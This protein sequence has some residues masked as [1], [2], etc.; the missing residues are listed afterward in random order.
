MY[1]DDNIWDPKGRKLIQSKQMFLLSISY[2]LVILF[3]DV[4]PAETCFIPWWQ[5][6]CK[7][8]KVTRKSR[9]DCV[10]SDDFNSWKII[11]SR[12]WKFLTSSN[13]GEVWAPHVWI[14]FKI[15]FINI[16]YK[17]IHTWHTYKL[18]HT[19]NTEFFL[20]RLMDMI[21]GHPGDGD[22]AVIWRLT[23]FSFLV[24]KYVRKKAK[25]NWFQISLN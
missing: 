24:D 20:T 5:H 6:S 2:S 10:A 15:D 11:I 23:A 8:K 14:L 17:Y 9:I 1:V 7:P 12:K 21:T 16:I 13:F 25:K 18:T 3:Y 4:T 19:H 22:C